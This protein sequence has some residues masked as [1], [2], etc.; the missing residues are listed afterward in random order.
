MVGLAYEEK[1]DLKSLIK[2]GVAFWKVT[3]ALTSSSPNL[4]QLYLWSSHYFLVCFFVNDPFSCDFYSRSQKWY[5]SL[6]YFVTG[7]SFDLEVMFHLTL[8]SPLW[9]FWCS[10]VIPCKVG[11]LTNMRTFFL[12]C[13]P[14]TMK[15][16]LKCC[17]WNNLYVGFIFFNLG[18]CLFKLPTHLIPRI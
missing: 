14:N 18:S 10:P 3:L 5:P 12:G 6:Y 1:T 13:F 4:L 17:A 16:S 2:T 7:V 15:E 11:P 9:S 8:T